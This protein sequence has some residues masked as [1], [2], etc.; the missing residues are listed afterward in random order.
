MSDNIITVL[1]GD[2]VTDIINKLV[3]S[4][5]SKKSG[6]NTNTNNTKERATKIGNGLRLIPVLPVE[7]Q[8]EQKQAETE[9]DDIK[10]YIIMATLAG[11]LQHRMTSKAITFHILANTKRYR[12]QRNDRIVA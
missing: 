8:Q 11:R 1:P 3:R 4:S 6:G 10:N 9:K 7:Q 2:D 5:S 12:P